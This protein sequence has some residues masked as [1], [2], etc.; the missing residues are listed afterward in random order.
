MINTAFIVS[1]FIAFIAGF[2][3]SS[4]INIYE[5]VREKYRQQN[6]ENEVM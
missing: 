1:M 6:K 3:L 4:A 2:L 5:Q